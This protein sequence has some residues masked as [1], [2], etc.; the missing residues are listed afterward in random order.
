MK[1]TKIILVF[2]MLISE[3][4]IS[5]EMLTDLNVPDGFEISILAEGLNTPR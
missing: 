1:S 5:D 4:L 2:A 3:L